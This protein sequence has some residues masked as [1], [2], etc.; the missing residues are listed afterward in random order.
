MRSAEDI[1]QDEQ[2]WTVA[3]VAHYARCSRALVYQKAASGELPACRPGGGSLL[4]FEPEVAKA[5]ARGEL[6]PAPV[7]PIR[8]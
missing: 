1:L 6:K 4:R 7:T 3:D 8:K 2:L 5:W